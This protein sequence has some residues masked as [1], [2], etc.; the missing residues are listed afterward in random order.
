MYGIMADIHF[1]ILLLIMDCLEI[2]K[3]ILYFW[4]ETLETDYKISASSSLF[5]ILV[6]ETGLSISPDQ[7]I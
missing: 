4:A 7:Y 1:N 5:F 2:I 6:S 3:L